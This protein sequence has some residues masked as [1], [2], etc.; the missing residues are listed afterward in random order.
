MEHKKSSI[1]WMI[2]LKH[3]LNG[4]VSRQDAEFE[5]LDPDGWDRTRLTKS[6]HELI[7]KEEYINRFSRSTVQKAVYQP[8]KP[9]ASSSRQKR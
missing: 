9:A 6:L 5:I 3:N 7:S 4:Y 8:L 2:E 1:D